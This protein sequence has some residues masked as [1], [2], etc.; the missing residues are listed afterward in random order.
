M[1][2][3][4]NQRTIEQ[5]FTAEV[6]VVFCIFRLV[7]LLENSAAALFLGLQEQCVLQR[8]IRQINHPKSLS[9]SEKKKVVTTAGQSEY[10]HP[11]RGGE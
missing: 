9:L 4:I 10:P 1:L 8:R 5:F 3:S 6:E 7:F 2:L 11:F